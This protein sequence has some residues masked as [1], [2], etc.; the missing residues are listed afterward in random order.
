MRNRIQET[1]RDIL[2]VVR[3]GVIA[4]LKPVVI[5][6][7]LP[8]QLPGR[9]TP[10]L[11]KVQRL[12]Q[13]IRDASTEIPA[14]KDEPFEWHRMDQYEIPWEAGSVVMELVGRFSKSRRPEQISGFFE[15]T[16]AANFTLSAQPTRSGQV[17]PRPTARQV[18]W[19]WRVRQVLPV[20][21]VV[22]VELLADRFAFAELGQ[23]IWG[24]PMQ[25][26]GL[27]KLLTECLNEESSQPLDLLERL[28]AL[29]AEYQTGESE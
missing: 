3:R 13:D 14:W 6:G 20:Q 15:S 5:C 21:S 12:V 1:E 27:E 23:D 4:G 9:K 10:N 26:E 18:I 8:E 7:Q 16:M 25:V 22:V 11:R 17:F 24:Q 19:F 29:I 28:A 2:D